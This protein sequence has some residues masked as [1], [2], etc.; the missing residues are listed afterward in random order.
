MTVATETKVSQVMQTKIVTAKPKANVFE[1]AKL[2]DNENVGSVLIVNDEG[3]L[4]G[5]VTDRQ[6]VIRVVA[7]KKDLSTTTADEIMT[8]W[9][10]SIFPDTTCKE[11]LDI[12][13]DYGFR[14]LPVEDK[15]KLIGIIS[16]S[17]LAPICEFDD[18]CIEDMV[19]ELSKDA[20]YK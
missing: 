13:G 8:K 20:R 4:L 5:L 1:L 11:A 15:N 6:V 12:M 2:M 17:D 14:R 9:P 7:T 18:E 10:M 16:I 3:K 19:N